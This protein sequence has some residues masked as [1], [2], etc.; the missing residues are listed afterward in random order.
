VLTVFPADKD[1]DAVVLGTSDYNQK[2]VTLMQDKAY[3][4]LKKDPADSIERKTVFLKKSQ[5]AEKVCQQ[6]RP[7]GSNPPRLFGFPKIHKHCVLLRPT[8]NTIV[9]PTYRL[10]QHLAG[11]LNGYTDHSPHHIKNSIDSVHALRSLP[12]DTHD[13]MVSFRVLSLFTK[14][15]IKEARIC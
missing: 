10:A 1:N 13:I 7:Q 9:F 8:L 15:P 4:K 14:L 5:F 11:P 2:I 3:A 12:V 6:L